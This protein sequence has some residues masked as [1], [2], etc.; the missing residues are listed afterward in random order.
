METVLVC[1]S[2]E[3]AYDLYQFFE[4]QFK[5]KHWEAYVIPVTDVAAVSTGVAAVVAHATDW[6]PEKLH[7]C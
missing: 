4:A 7:E 3:A 2:P 1:L 5:G 6:P